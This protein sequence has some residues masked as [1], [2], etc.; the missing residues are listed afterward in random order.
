MKRGKSQRREPWSR[1]LRGYRHWN[2]SDKWLKKVFL[3]SR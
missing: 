2:R 3:A 1:G